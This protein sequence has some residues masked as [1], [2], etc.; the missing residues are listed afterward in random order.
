MNELLSNFTEKKEA[1]PVCVVRLTTN[2][3]GDN[4]GLYSKQGLTF[5]RRKSSG[6]QILEEDISMVGAEQV[7][8]RIT[9]L[10]EC[11]DGIYKV[12]TCNESHDWETPHI[13]DDYDYKLIPFATENNNV[14]P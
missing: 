13:I 14:T 6:F 12:I 4:K 7:F 2:F 1:P 3:W 5:L 11:K 9:N 8:P 10:S